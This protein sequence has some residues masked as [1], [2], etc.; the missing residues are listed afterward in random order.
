MRILD[1]IRGRLWLPHDG[2]WTGVF[3]VLSLIKSLI[4]REKAVACSNFA[5]FHNKLVCFLKDGSLI[6]LHCPERLSL[7]FKFPS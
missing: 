6:V 4:L 1:F 7:I 3:F 2:L 5:Y